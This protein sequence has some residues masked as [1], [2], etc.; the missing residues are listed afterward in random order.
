MQE[1][2]RES[3]LK[4]KLGKLAS[5]IAKIGYIG[6]IF[7]A[8][9]YLFQNIFID[10][11]FDINQIKGIVTNIPVLLNLVLD[12]IILAVIIIVVAVPEGLPMMI[13]LVLAMN[14][15]KMMKDNVLVRKI[16][17]IETAGGLNILFSDKTGTIT[18]GKLSVSEIIDGDINRY[19]SM[20]EMTPIFSDELTIGIGLNNSSSISNKAIIGGNMTDRCLMTY[21]LDN[22]K[23]KNIDKEAVVEFTPFN[24]VKNIQQL[25]QIQI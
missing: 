11:G 16:N 22:D 7:I 18:E 14:M 4:V 12:S 20:K 15:G 3:P 13:A 5:I 19:S 25:L 17:G 21:L 9:A 2:T 6:G 1:E 10:T 23:E 24:S 8:I